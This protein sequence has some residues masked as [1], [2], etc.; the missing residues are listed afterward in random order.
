MARRY[1]DWLQQARRDLKAAKDSLADDNFEWAAFQAQQAAEKAVKALLR[2]HH[3]EMEG[4]T[5]IHLLG[6][7]TEFTEVR[8]ELHAIAREL[9]RHYIQPR[10]PNAFPEGYPGE[11]YDQA[12]A[13]RCIQHAEE[14]LRFVEARVS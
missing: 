3:Y 7:A 12:V 14:F 10:Y 9:D 1:Q 11:F 8:E 4:H 13:D 2:F 6:K 5:L